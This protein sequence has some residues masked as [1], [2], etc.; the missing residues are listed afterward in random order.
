MLFLNEPFLFCFSLS[1]SLEATRSVEMLSASISLRLQVQ[2]SSADVQLPKMW[3]L[4]PHCVLLN[5]A[6]AQGFARL[7]VIATWYRFK[8]SMG[9][10][11]YSSEKDNAIQT[12]WTFELC[13]WY[14]VKPQIYKIK[15]EQNKS[16]LAFIPFPDFAL[17]CQQSRPF[18]YKQMAHNS[19]GFSHIWWTHIKSIYMTMENIK[20][21]TR[22]VW[23]KTPGARCCQQA[24]EVRIFWHTVTIL[25]T[26]PFL[27]QVIASFDT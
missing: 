14:D 4:H 24:S 6:C 23:C 22:S 18:A 19:V 17:N 1:F 26:E 8:S 20:M 21:T 7:Q 11:Q 2:G 3:S 15:T 9:L 10:R 16:V 25:G 5:P 13:F 27:T 12:E